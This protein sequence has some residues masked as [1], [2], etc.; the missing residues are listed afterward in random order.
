MKK[1]ITS[2]TF[3]LLGML[4]AVPAH[5][6][7]TRFASA[8]TDPSRAVE[9]ESRAAALYNAPNK[10]REAARLHEEAAGLRA[11]DDEMKVENLRQAARLYYYTGAKRQA[12]VAMERAGDA[13]LAAGDVVNAAS[14]YLDAAFLFRAG[15][16]AADVQRMIRKAQL[17]TNSPLLSAQDRASILGRIAA[18]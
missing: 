15:K 8:T 17:L 12:W 11:A 16:Q 2:G 13:A 5:A 3:L 1:T 7:S 18:A 6:Q 14:S 9:L 10:F 4:V